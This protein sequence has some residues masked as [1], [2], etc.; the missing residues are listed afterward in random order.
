MG[1]MTKCGIHI[2]ALLNERGMTKKALAQYLGIS[3]NSL[4]NKM[5]GYQFFTQEEIQ[6]IKIL[7]NL[8]PEQLDKIFFYTKSSLVDNIG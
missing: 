2:S 3:V 7:F 8:S 1:R 5:Y 6:K 4:Y